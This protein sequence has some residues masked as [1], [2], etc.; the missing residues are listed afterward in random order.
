MA[1]SVTQAVGDMPPVEG[2]SKHFHVGVVFARGWQLGTSDCRHFRDGPREE[3]RMPPVAESGAELERL[4]APHL[5]G[6]L[7]VALAA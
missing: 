1:L 5:A 3:I 6:A 4:L 2:I 7:T